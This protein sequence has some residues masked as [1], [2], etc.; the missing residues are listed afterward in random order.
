[1]RVPTGRP[2]SKPEAEQLLSVID[3][4]DDAV[5]QGLTVA[6]AIVLGVVD[7]LAWPRL[8]A[9]ASE[10]AHWSERRVERLLSLDR[11]YLEDL[12]LELNEVRQLEHH[13]PAGSG[14]SAREAAGAMERVLT[15][16]AARDSG[17]MR[18]AIR[19]VEELDVASTFRL[20]AAL[21]DLLA[22]AIDRGEVVTRADLDR[23]ADALGP[24]PLAA[25]V[26]MI[27]A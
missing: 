17:A 5:I 8:I 6:L 27:E 13:V 20:A 7:D 26:E 22:D 4:D 11:L 12:L 3:A 2:L 9:S 14:Q 18:S 10:R 24:G 23:V 19:K 25:I 15:G 16:L 21:C 1:V